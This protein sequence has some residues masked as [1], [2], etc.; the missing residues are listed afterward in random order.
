LDEFLDPIPARL[1]LTGKRID[2]S[3]EGGEYATH[4]ADREHGH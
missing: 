1:A 4:D 3:I 2:V